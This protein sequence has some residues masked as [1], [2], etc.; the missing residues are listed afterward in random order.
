MKLNKVYNIQLE[1]LD[2]GKWSRRFLL[3]NKS[4][5]RRPNSVQVSIE[6]Y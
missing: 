4:L 5:Q 2:P 1:D 3:R 6:I